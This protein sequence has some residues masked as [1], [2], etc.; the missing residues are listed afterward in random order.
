VTQPLP[1]Q[2]S[3]ALNK[4]GVFLKKRVIDTLQKTPGITIIG[5]EIGFSFGG[6]RVLD[7]LAM[8]MRKQPHVLFAFECK[9][10]FEKR[11]Y[12]FRDLD[13]RYRVARVQSNS[14]GTSSVYD[15]SEL[16]HPEVC[17]EGFEF[18]GNKN[19][20][21]DPIFRTGAQLSAAYLGL[22]ARRRQEFQR[23]PPN[24]DVVE[25][26]V[27]VLVTNAELWV[28]YSDFSTVN[29][30]TGI[31][32]SPKAALKEFV[33][34]KQP[35]PTPDALTVDFRDHPAAPEEA[36]HWPQC[37]KESIYVVTAKHLPE[38]LETKH[39]DFLRGELAE[40]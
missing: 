11:W 9:K 29:L 25:R 38:F 3:E 4:H 19:V 32:P 21:Q 18:A 39:R 22:I 6:T 1:Q 27:P 36:Q 2:E 20:D 28:D 24:V 34:L 40:E 7:V 15:I 14:M 13:K 31:L 37:H 8:D 16:P 17:S 33:I 12:F 23:A 26:Y 5:E 30:E 35:F 10:V